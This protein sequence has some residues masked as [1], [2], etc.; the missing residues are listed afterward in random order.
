MSTVFKAW[1]NLLN[2]SPF[3]QKLDLFH[4]WEFRNTRM[5]A[6]I[7]ILAFLIQSISRQRQGWLGSHSEPRTSGRTSS[8]TLRRRWRW[9]GDATIWKSTMTAFWAPRPW[10]WFWLTSFRAR[11]A[12]TQRCLVPKR[13]AS[14][15]PSW[16]PESLRRWTLRCLGKKRG[17]PSLRTAAVVCTGF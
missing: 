4:V 1:L 15:R 2:A 3:S 6:E 17:K 8:T 7:I 14:A 10:T 16:R 5:Q 12:E 13:S 11:S 9:R